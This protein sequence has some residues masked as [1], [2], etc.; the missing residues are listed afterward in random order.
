MFTVDTLHRAEHLR[1]WHLSD[2]TVSRRT[3]YY[4]P[5]WVSSFNTLPGP[6]RSSSLV[7]D[8]SS[9]GRVS[10]FLDRFVGGDRRDT[11]E[12]PAGDAR[13]PMFKR[14]WS[15]NEAVVEMGTWHTRTF[16]FF[17]RENFFVGVTLETVTRL[18]EQE[19]LY[20]QGLATSLYF[21]NAAVVQKLLSRI[22][23][24]CVDAVTNVKELVTDV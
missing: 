6:K 8:T 24:S 14:M 2:G 19:K 22:S 10:G 3:F 9:R 23:P 21:D 13:A 4:R 16:G 20:R 5:A 7:R 17:V 1:Q 15:P 11:L 12:T 18:K